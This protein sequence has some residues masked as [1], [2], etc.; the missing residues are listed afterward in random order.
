MTAIAKLLN[1]GSVAIV[2]ASAD[3]AKTSG[4]PVHFLRKHGFKGA[5]YPVNPRVA[6]ID[7]LT[8]YPNVAALPEA[9]DVGMVLLGA[10]RAHVAV[11]ELAARGTHAAIVLA[12]GYGEVGP[13]GATRQ[14]ELLDAA[15]SMRLLGPNTIG[16]VNLTDRI[17]LS[18]SGALDIADFAEGSIA[19]ISQSGG[20]LGS[21]L[22]RANGRGI[23]LSKLIS[24]S[25]EADLEAAD[26]INFLV[27]DPSTSVIALYIESIR[28]PARFCAAA[29]RA[30]RAGKPIVAYKIGRSEQGAQAASSHTGA[31]AGSDRA[32]D[33]FFRQT[34]VIRAETFSD[35]LDIPLALSTNRRLRGKRIA[36]LT[37]TGGAGTLVTDNLGLRGFE[38]PPPDA[39]TAARLRAL[40]LG[41]HTVVDRNPIDVTL[42][43]LQ[44]DL[45]SGAIEA[46]LDSP[47]YDALTIIVGSS[48]VSQ[49]ELMA[50]AIKPRLAMTDKPV[51]AYV[52][53]NAPQAAAVLTSYGVPTF[54]AP[55]GCAN[56]FAAMLRAGLPTAM[57]LA[58][59]PR[60]V[61]S[62]QTRLQSGCLDE[63]EAKAL[64]AEF[65]IS[66][67]AEIVVTT[68]SE[69]T[70]AA[71]KLGGRVAL[72][73][74]S[75]SILHKSDV[76]G[77]AIALTADTI[78]MALTRMNETVQ[79]RT[80]V[81]PERFL[82]QQMVT[83]G[84]EIIL[85][86]K[87]DPL[88]MVLLLGAGGTSAE[89]FKDT[90][91]HLLDPKQA[92]TI[93]DAHTM[94]REL[95]SWPLLDGYR[96]RPKADVDSLA[97]AIVAYADLAS[98]LGDRLIEAE[99]NP[100]FVLPAG[101]GVCAADGVVVLT[102]QQAAQSSHST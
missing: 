1:P 49:P 88:G 27:D 81:T 54:A 60:V 17:S 33:A 57:P 78:G 94:A 89:L 68:A 73:V 83:G 74:L 66:G 7:G 80:G 56:A 58:A 42:A 52:S 48:G 2:G 26:F 86:L 82:V 76:G 84:T 21:L 18:A 97:R 32:Y 95:K 67:A 90:T 22:S 9:P 45:L 35:L 96:G 10:E 47:S 41:E 31:L 15:G 61:R 3:V 24:T 37:S 4:K 20:I 62:I 98:A 55:E 8:C 70:A 69:A 40:Q 100:L 64:F 29:S 85:G 102:E 77:V 34:G 87:R 53:P 5:I 38:T 44:H 63:A 30:S 59:V 11:R 50:G 79:S 13:A 91:L 14:A 92:M 36:V 101:Q 16:L 39:A 12:S 6:N 28:D 25:N 23:G 99:I 51:L 71:A 75:R 72:K 93:D 43:G 19:V 65:G 46:L